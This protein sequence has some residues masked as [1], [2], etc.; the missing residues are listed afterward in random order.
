MG[1]R[2]TRQGIR[3]PT[4]F[5]CRPIP[6]AAGGENFPGGRCYAILVSWGRKRKNLRA[7]NTK[8]SE[9]SRIQLCMRGIGEEEHCAPNHPPL[10]RAD[11]RADMADTRDQHQAD[12]RR[13]SPLHDWVAQLL[14]ILRDPQ[15]T[16]G[17]GRMDPKAP[18]LHDMETVD[19]RDGPLQGTTE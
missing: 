16:Q 4:L 14:R 2:I 19:A 17:L 1:V 5:S 11:S 18:T 12:D 15:H 6:M 13:A 3:T 10:Q 7:G 8:G 9:V